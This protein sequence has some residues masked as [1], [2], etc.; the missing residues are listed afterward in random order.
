MSFSLLVCLKTHLRSR[1]KLLFTSF[2][3]IIFV[4]GICL[5]IVFSH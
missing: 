5:H 1:T 2:V 3:L 4:N